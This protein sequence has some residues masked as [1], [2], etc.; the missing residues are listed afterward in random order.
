MSFLNQPAFSLTDFRHIKELIRLK[1]PTVRLDE[2]PVRVR[3]GLQIV[4]ILEGKF[5][6]LVDNQRY[7]LYPNDVVVLCP[8]HGYGSPTHTLEI[9]SLLWITLEPETFEVNRE[10]YL[11]EWSSLIESDQKLMGR[12]FVAQSPMVLNNFKWA[13]E[14]IQRIETELKQAEFAYQ[15][16]VNQLLDEL[17]VTIVRQLSQQQNQRR[18][19]PQAF[20]QLEQLLR[21][22]LDHPW[23]VEEMATV[24]GLGSTAFTEKVKAFSGFSPLNYLINIRIA[25]AMKQLRQTAKSL[26]DIALDTGFYSSQHFSTTFKKLTGYTPGQFRK[27]GKP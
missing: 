7:V 27:R 21:D 10:L 16:R 13:F 24:V 1:N 5:E 19:F 18:D 23:T 12:L 4:C 20:A 14:L 9:G 15:T 17:L 8:W 2:W 6:W 3:G 26:T 22:S 11:G 25:E